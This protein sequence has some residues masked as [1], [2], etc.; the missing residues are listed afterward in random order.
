MFSSFLLCSEEADISQLDL[1]LGL[2]NGILYKNMFSCGSFVCS[3]LGKQFLFS[4][5][6]MQKYCDEKCNLE[7]KS[8][9]RRH[10]LLE[11]PIES[12]FS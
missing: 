7:T 9:H 11:V 4:A 8:S 6:V 2:D 12:H 10:Y 5:E 1:K 3:Y